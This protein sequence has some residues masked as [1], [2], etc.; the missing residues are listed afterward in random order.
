MDP[1]AVSVTVLASDYK[2]Q[3]II[4]TLPLQPTRLYRYIDASWFLLTEQGSENA[5]SADL[6]NSMGISL[7]VCCTPRPFHGSEAKEENLQS[8]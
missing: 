2:Q 6:W 7:T 1:L 8:F 3:V 4:R 5:V